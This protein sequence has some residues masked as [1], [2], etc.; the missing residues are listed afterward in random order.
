MSFLE[1]GSGHPVGFSGRA[2]LPEKG[3][4]LNLPPAALLLGYSPLRDAPSSR[5]ASGSVA[6]PPNG[7]L[8]PFQTLRID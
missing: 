5:L 4:E 2:V 3:Q 8:I 7:T 1:E 6:L